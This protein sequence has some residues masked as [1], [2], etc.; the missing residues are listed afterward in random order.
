MRRSMIPE[1]DSKRIHEAL[2]NWL[3]RDSDDAFSKYE[4]ICVE[5]LYRELENIKVSAYN[6]VLDAVIKNFGE[7]VYKHTVLQIKQLKEEGYM[8]LA[9]SGSE[10][11]AVARF[12]K[13]YGFDDYVG[14]D[15]HKDGFYFTG[16]ATDVVHNKHVYLQQLIDKHKLDRHDSIGYGDTGSDIEMLKMV[17]EPICFNPNRELFNHAKIMGWKIVVERKNVTYELQK[18]RH[19]YQLLADRW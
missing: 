3:H 12:C 17:S 2:N 5:V 14:V 18:G 8:V 15:F 6:S 10:Q 7:R 9:V 11:K 19:G 1:A 16:A 13:L 4:N